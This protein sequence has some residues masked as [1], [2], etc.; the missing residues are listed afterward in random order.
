MRLLLASLCALALALTACSHPNRPRVVEDRV[1]GQVTIR[2]AQIWHRDDSHG[3]VVG[4]YTRG[5]VSWLATPGELDPAGYPVVRAVFDVPVV[6][7]Y[8]E[9]STETPEIF[10]L[11]EGEAGGERFSLRGQALGVT[12]NPTVYGPLPQMGVFA[13]GSPPVSNARYWSGII[14][15]VPWPRLVAMTRARRTTVA[16]SAFT[17]TL[18]QVDMAKGFVECVEHPDQ[19]ERSDR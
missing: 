17:G 6:G 5:Q 9:Q 10:F 13:P 8:R 18:E 2:A 1:R 16:V 7:G 11:V 19:C 12:S 14:A 4:Q 3:L 15:V